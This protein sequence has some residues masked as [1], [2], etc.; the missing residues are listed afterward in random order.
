MLRLRQLFQLKAS[1]KSNRAIS[2]L[3]SINRKTINDYVNR[4]TTLNLDFA[5]LAAGKDETL[6]DWLGKVPVIKIPDKQRKETL[7]SLFPGIQKELGHNGVDRYVLWE[8]YQSAHDNPYSYN[9]FCREFKK[10]CIIQNVSGV[11]EHKA[12]DKLYIDFAGKKMQITN[13]ETGEVEN[14]EVF[15]AILGFS[16][17]TYV[18]VT[19]SQKKEEVIH[20]T[21][22]ALHYIGGV[23]QAIVCDNLKSAVYKASKYEPELNE[24]YERFALHYGTTILPTRPRKPKDKPM[25]EGAVKITYRRIKAVLRNRVFFSIEELNNAI[26]ELLVHYNN[27]VSKHATDTRRNLLEQVENAE[28]QPLPADRYEIYEYRWCQVYKTSYILLPEDS[29]Y[30]SVPYELIGKRVK[31]VYNSRT[32]EIYYQMKRMALHNRD[33]RPKGHTTIA[34]HLPSN[35]QFVNEATAEKLISWAGS[36]GTNTQQ[37]VV[38]IINNRK[39]FDQ[40]RKSCMGILSLGKK[41]GKERL[42]KACHRAIYFDYYSYKAV[43][44]ILQSNLESEPLQMELEL[45]NYTLSNHENI[46]GSSYYQ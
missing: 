28:L 24:S 21:E 26:R 27:K 11:T 33:C 25:V 35:L 18:E 17:F 6:Q 42:E 23:P 13:R 14:V 2:K 20:A 41:L 32:V 29:H 34:E 15:V 31:L 37:L 19:A 5:T 46:R 22:N 39:H 45:D 38:F 9:H 10:W 7:K 12:G 43:K 16:Q 36:V 44:G 40:A 3:L 30:Y 4:A 8:E 1:G